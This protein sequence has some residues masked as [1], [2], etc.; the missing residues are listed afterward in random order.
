MSPVKWFNFHLSREDLGGPL[1]TQFKLLLFS[2][3]LVIVFIFFILL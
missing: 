3:D 2:M 1:F